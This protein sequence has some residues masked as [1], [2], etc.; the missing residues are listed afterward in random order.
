MLQQILYFF[1]GMG[2]GVGVDFDGV[3]SSKSIGSSNPLFREFLFSSNEFAVADD[4][5]GCSTNLTPLFPL[6]NEILL[7]SLMSVN[8]INGILIAGGVGL[9]GTGT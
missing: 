2:G 6:A 1:E 4:D 7:S 3:S 5:G 9:A 8:F